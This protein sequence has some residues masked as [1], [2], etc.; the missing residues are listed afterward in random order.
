M[1]KTIVSIEKVTKYFG[2]K[3][4]QVAAVKEVSLEIEEGSYTVILGR[5]GSGKS[6]LLNLMAGLDKVSS[7]RLVVADQDLSKINSRELAK[8]R[9]KIGI[10]FQA[11]NL[12][13]N[14]NTVENVLIGGWASGK[15]VQEKDASAILE[16]L[17]LTHRVGA[18]VKTLSGGEKQRVAIGRSLISNPEILFCDEPTGALDSTSEKQVQDILE[19]LHKEKKLTIVLVTHNPDFV[20]YADKVVKMEDGRIVSVEKTG[21]K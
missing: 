16:S 10:I 18:N 17:G 9:S 20:Q 7:G 5:S 15:N 13:P 21:R 8:Y 1:S 19:K 6:T 2:T 3:D 14:L 11:Y 12:L 4:S